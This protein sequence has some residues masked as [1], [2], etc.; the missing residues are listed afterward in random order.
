ML[1]SHSP[2]ILLIDIMIEEGRCPVN[3]VNGRS[4]SWT[5]GIAVPQILA[6]K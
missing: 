5:R 6:M 1:Y 3:E 2:F 4:P